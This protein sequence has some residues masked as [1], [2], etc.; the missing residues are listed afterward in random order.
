MFHPSHLESKL[1]V[2]SKS[3]KLIGFIIV[4]PLQAVKT[5]E[6]QSHTIRDE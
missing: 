1:K 3:Q 5:A 2:T 6:K 4:I